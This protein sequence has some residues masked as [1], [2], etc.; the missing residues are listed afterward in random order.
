MGRPSLEMRIAVPVGIFGR[1]G[2]ER[3]LLGGI[4][5][6]PFSQPRGFR[7]RA[8]PTMNLKHCLLRRIAVVTLFMALFP[9][10]LGQTP[11]QVEAAKG[12]LGATPAA[13]VAARCVDLVAGAPQAE[14]AAVAASLVAAV[15]A[16]QG[17]SL[18][19]TV[20]GISARLPRIAPAAAAAAA[21]A[22]PAAASSYVT[23]LAAIPGV[24]RREVLV[25]VIAAVPQ[26]AARCLQAAGRKAA[27]L[28]GREP[29]RL[30]K[31]GVVSTR[32]S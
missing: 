15:A 17:P 11:G 10:G 32:E 19:A 29:H 2:L 1:F 22:E 13:E 25:A 16:T 24:N 5:T 14:Q 31:V 26:E 6:I 20:L 28:Q 12:I 18:R 4:R 27:G 21:E 3:N 9:Q 7:V 30:V 23:E 8:V